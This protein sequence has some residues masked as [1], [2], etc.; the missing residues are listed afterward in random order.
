MVG[1]CSFH[2]DL[3]KCKFKLLATDCTAGIC[4]PNRNI[5]TFRATFIYSCDDLVC[6]LYVRNNH[7]GESIKRELTAIPVDQPV[8][9]REIR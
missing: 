7:T 1:A 6:G 9:V 4:K 3:Y 5:G 2:A 8:H